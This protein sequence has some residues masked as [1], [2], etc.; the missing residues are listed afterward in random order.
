MRQIL[1]QI[2]QPISADI[3]RFKDAYRMALQSDNPLLMQMVKHVI[4]SSGKQMRP[5]L[6]LLCAQL[7][8]KIT[9]ASIHAAVS[10]ELLHVASLIHDDVIDESD[11]RRGQPSLL[12]K[13]QSKMAV[14]GGDYFLSTALSEAVKTRNIEVVDAIASMGKILVDGELLQL[15]GSKN[16]I[17]QENYY[18]DVIKA[19][20]ASL[21]CTCTKLGA[22]TATQY[23]ASQLEN[24]KK[25]GEAIGICFQ[26]KDDVFD[27]QKGGHIGKPIGNDIQEGKMTLPLLYVYE[28][29][30]EKE[31]ESILAA[32][33]Q[34]DIATICKLVEEKGGMAY[35]QQKITYYKEKAL[36]CLQDFEETPARKA[37][38]QYITLVAD[39][40][41]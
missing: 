31:K 8:G 19:K 4:N 7:C 22:I 15:S 36:Q 25:L 30:T 2:S 3:V 20:T 13:F 21:F 10:I 40:Q 16:A 35:T 41:K 39:R 38:E 34:K 9:E 6:V 23:T 18:F 11:E 24:A 1:Q 27:Y 37:I 32:F 29:A 5:L 12:A 17:Y 33:E 26:L 14:L 28:Q